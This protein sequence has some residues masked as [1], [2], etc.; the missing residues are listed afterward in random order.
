MD[1]AIIKTGSK[2]YKVKP[3]D[4]VD[5]EK[6]PAEE[7]SSVELTD[8]LAI[9]RDGELIVGNP[10]V[11]ESSVVAQVRSQARDKKII[12]FKYKRKVRY[13]RKKGHRQHYTRLFITSI[14]LDGEEIGIQ[15]WPGYL[16]RIQD[17]PVPEDVSDQ[18]EDEDQLGDEVPV[19][20]EVESAEDNPDEPGDGIQDESVDE[21]DEGSQDDTADEPVTEADMPV[22]E[23][24]EKSK[25]KTGGRTRRQ[26]VKGNGP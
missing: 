5:V 23:A 6:L 2:Q 24:E 7:G 16:T 19:Q 12:V 17:E 20:I 14:V 3:G 11:P 8:V 1:Y 18:V 10:L 9:S 13:R 25:S 21:L 26:K 22:Q 4:V 15:E